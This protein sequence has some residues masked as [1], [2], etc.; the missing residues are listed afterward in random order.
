LKLK[1]KAEFALGT[2]KH[3]GKKVERKEE[4]KKWLNTMRF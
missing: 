3:F 1:I 4:L 2:L